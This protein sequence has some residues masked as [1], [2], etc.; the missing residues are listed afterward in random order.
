MARR[1]ALVML[2]LWTVAAVLGGCT[3]GGLQ[4]PAIATTTPA[5]TPEWIP[6][7]IQKPDG[8]GPFPAVVIMHDC[9]GLGP[10]SSGAPGRWARELVGRGYVVLMPDSFTTRG[11]PAGLCTNPS[12]RRN[13][14][15]PSRRV[16]DAYAAL[17]HL[18]TLPFVDGSRVGLM[19][20]SH[21]GATTLAAMVAPSASPGF[22]AAVALYPG[23]APWLRSGTTG[24][25]DGYRPAGPLLILIGE[26]DDW[27]PAE[28]CR[29]LAEAAQRA[30]SPVTIKVYPGAYHSFDS[31]NPVRYVATRVNANST[32]GRGAT[33]GG[34]PEAWADSI[35]E[36]TAFFGRYLK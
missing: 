22:R 12:P 18:R 1:E 2:A 19:G 16:R 17:A 6:I 15:G 30:G 14:V 24:A 29:R 20:G 26:K 31:A 4:G 10:S 8:P 11:F 36:V 35:R 23:C 32:T 25:D 21:G 13:D 33:T 5:G 27:T 9:S 28:P 7:Q 3:V 34:D